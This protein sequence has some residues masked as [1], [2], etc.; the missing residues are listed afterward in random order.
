MEAIKN[1]APAKSA[2][3]SKQINLY[4]NLKQQEAALKEH[5]ALVRGYLVEALDAAE[6]NVLA[7]SSHTVTRS[8]KTRRGVDTK[9]VKALL[10]DDTP[11]K[12]T[13]YQELKV[14]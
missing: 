4:A 5:L 3:L 13:T 10:G 2:H 1:I 9:A 6:T 8:T 12:E 7:S 11:M 14:L